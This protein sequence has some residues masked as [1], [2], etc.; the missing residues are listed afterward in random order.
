MLNGDGG[1][2]V[3]REIYWRAVYDNPFLFCATASFYGCIWAFYRVRL[4]RVPC[5]GRVL[6]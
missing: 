6:L 1:E 4:S 3:S 2:Q 5:E